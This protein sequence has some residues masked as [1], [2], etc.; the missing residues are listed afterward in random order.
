MLLL[1]L[2]DWLLQLT[3]AADP[4]TG[5]L[6]PAVSNS[7]SNSNSNSDSSSNSSSSSS[8]SD[9]AVEIPTVLSLPCGADMDKAAR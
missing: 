2:Q 3:E 4:D 1:L 7:N 8:G 5:E 9:A 6:L